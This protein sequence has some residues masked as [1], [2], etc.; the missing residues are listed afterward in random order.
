MSEVIMTVAAIALA[1]ATGVTAYQ[2]RSIQADK[3][4]LGTWTSVEPF[5]GSGLTTDVRTISFRIEG[6]E[7]S[8][9]AWSGLLSRLDEVHEELSPFGANARRPP[10]EYRTWCG[11]TV[12]Y[13]D[14]PG[15]YDRRYLENYIRVLETLAGEDAR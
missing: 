13:P 1:L 3:Y 6:A 12:V 9:E 5:R 11:R 8:P 14:A 7:A 10:F 4:E 15:R 2:L